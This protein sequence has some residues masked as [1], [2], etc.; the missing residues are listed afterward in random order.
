MS[1][2]RSETK[3]NN[4]IKA[5]KTLMN[6]SDKPDVILNARE[7]TETLSCSEIDPSTLCRF[8]CP[9]DFIPKTAAFCDSMFSKA[10]YCEECGDCWYLALT[11]EKKAAVRK[12]PRKA[13]KEGVKELL[14]I[15]GYKDGD[16]FDKFLDHIRKTH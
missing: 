5:A 12:A 9:H 13:D 6:S 4:F 14:N 15:L 1:R 16:D 7:F 2:C 11:E 3:I 8:G 10:T